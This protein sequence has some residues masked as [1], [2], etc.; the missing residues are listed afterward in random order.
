[1]EKIGLKRLE[2]SCLELMFENESAL[3]SENE[4]ALES[5]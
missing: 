2:T 1:M 4:S 3:K 5:A